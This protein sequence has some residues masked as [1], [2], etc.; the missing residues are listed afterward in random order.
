MHIPKFLE[1]SGEFLLFI[2]LQKSAGG[3]S[4]ETS[5]ARDLKA[6]LL[7]PIKC[8]LRASKLYHF[9]AD[10]PNEIHAGQDGFFTR[11]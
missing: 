8:I 5:L 11:W 2:T 10:D 3:V 6:D 9:S 7:R 4:R 1:M